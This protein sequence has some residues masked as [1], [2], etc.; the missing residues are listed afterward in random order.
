MNTET[1]GSIGSVRQVLYDHYHDFTLTINVN[2]ANKIVPTGAST[3]SKTTLAWGEQLSTITLSGA[4]KD[5]DTEVKGTFAWTNSATT[6]SDMNDF[7]AEWKF[8]PENTDVYAE[9]TDTVTIKV[10]KATP[11]GAPKYTAI[12]ASGKTLADAALGGQ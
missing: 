12:N 9:I 8:T 2:A 11:T 6:P 7:E 4:M 5:G 10:I 3:R 1:T